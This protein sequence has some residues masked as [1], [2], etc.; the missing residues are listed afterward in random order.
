LDLLENYSVQVIIGPQTS[1]QAAF[2]SDLGN[3]TQKYDVAIGDITIS[4]NRTSYVDFTLPYTE[5]GVAMVV[6]A[7]SSRT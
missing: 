5:S 3:K 6:P 1:S 7:K 2:V 4:H